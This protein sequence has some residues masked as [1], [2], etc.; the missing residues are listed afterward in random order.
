MTAKDVKQ[1][2]A[3]LYN[4]FKNGLFGLLMPSFLS[5]LYILSISSL[6]DVGLVRVFSH[7]IGCR[8]VLL[9]LSF[10]LQ[11]LFSFMRFHLLILILSA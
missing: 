11:K 10:A 3:H 8:F 7:P 9:S 2:L 5:Y 4:I 6:L 1:S